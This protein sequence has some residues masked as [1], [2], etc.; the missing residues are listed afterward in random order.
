MSMTTP[1]PLA[2]RLIEPV[3]TGFVLGL[4][5]LVWAVVLVPAIALGPSGTAVLFAAVGGVAAAQTAR[6]WRAAGLRPS[7]AVAGW[8]S[9]LVVLVSVMGLGWAGASLV[10]LVAAAAVAGVMV[11]GPGGV[12]VTTGATVRSALGPVIVGV[13]MVQL[14]DLGWAV[15]GIL[16]GLALGYDL[17]CHV[18]S[19]D[20]AGPV[21]GRVVGMVTVLVLT[22]AVSA[23]HT[24]FE[25]DPFG[26]AAAVWV[27]GA[28]AAVLCPLGPMV[29]STMLPSASAGAPALRRLDV[30]IVA[31]PMWMAAMWGYLG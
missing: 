28:L 2:E 26:P 21:V 23:V 24:L 17:A 3:R 25:L 30:L 27:F 18:W 22:L 15:A 4:R 11:P 7:R 19:S 29:A 10:A 31:A 14:S 1:D 8:G 12:L 13:S 16:V 5:S 6:A 20:G 9:L